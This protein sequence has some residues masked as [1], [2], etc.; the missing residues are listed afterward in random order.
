[1]FP[2][3]YQLQAYCDRS[4]NDK[5]Q[6]QV[7]EDRSVEFHVEALKIRKMVESV[8]NISTIAVRKK[9]TSSFAK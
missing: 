3:I 5:E 6:C 8:N 1:M 4:D 7:L 9:H 2:L